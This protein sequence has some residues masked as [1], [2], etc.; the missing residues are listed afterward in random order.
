LED[1]EKVNLS[2]VVKDSGMGIKEEAL[3]QIFEAFGQQS[4]QSATSSLGGQVWGSPS[5][6]G[7]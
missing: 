4:G 6:S 5:P 2:M 7:W 3:E 1:K